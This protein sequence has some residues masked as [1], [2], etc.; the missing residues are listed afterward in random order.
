VT[1]KD[2][3]N[4][5]DPLDIK[6]KKSKNDR[7]GVKFLF[8]IFVWLLLPTNCSCIVGYYYTWSHSVK[9]TNSV[10]PLWMRDQ[11]DTE[12]STWQHNTHNRQTSIG[13]LW[14]SDQLVAETSTWQHTTLTT[15]IHRSP[16]DKWSARRR[17]LHLTTHNTHNR[18]TSIGLLWMSDQLVAETSTWQHT[19]LTIYK[20]PLDSSGQV[21]S[22][23]Q[24]P[25]PD[26]TQLSQESDLHS[27]PQSQQ[28][29]GRRQ[30][31]Y[32]ARPPRSARVKVILKCAIPVLYIN[33]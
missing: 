8:S 13:L 14:T 9:H 19:T 3:V 23:T 25:P 16:L 11:P 15:D 33:K 4:F 2:L 21:I 27:N 17:D 12:T 31:P 1:L 18:Q 5:S 22:P 7:F 20:H 32:I 29:S 10:R 24:R 26:N 6:K 28:A 30:T